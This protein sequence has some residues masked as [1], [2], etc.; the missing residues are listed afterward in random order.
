MILV[1]P[2]LLYFFNLIVILRSVDLLF[3][4]CIQSKFFLFLRHYN[5]FF[6]SLFYSFDLFRHYYM[7]KK[8]DPIYIVKFSLF[9]SIWYLIYIHCPLLL[10]PSYN[11]SKKSWPISLNFLDI[12]FNEIYRLSKKKWPRLYSKLLYKMSRYFFDIQYVALMWF[13]FLLQL[14]FQN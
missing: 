14:I 8:Y 9:L 6:D 13:F 7:S 5:F 3:H 12:Q 11:L 1:D 10:Y 2:S 4:V